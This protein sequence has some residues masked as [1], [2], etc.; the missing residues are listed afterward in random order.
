MT[1]QLEWTDY[2]TEPG[3]YWVC[4]LGRNVLLLPVMESRFGTPEGLPP[5]YIDSSGAC[6]NGLTL[7]GKPILRY[8][9]PWYLFAGPLKSPPHEHLRQAYEKDEKEH[10]D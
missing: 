7:G 5:D 4:L 1:D 10:N 9:R 3:Y 6:R 8:G 2:P